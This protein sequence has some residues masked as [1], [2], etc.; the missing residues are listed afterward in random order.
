MQDPVSFE[1]AFRELEQVVKAL[2][3]GDLPLSQTI[4]L[5]ERGTK[6]AALCDRQLSD[7][8]LRVREIV[9]DGAEGYAAVP[10]DG[11]QPE[12]AS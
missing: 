5:F 7:A 2:E 12:D 10:F 3:E 8:E 9:S 11:W 6:L 4:E 1:E